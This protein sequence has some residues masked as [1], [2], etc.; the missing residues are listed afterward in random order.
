MNIHFEVL[1]VNEDLIARMIRWYND[2]EIA[3]F[4]HCNFQAQEPP[5]FTRTEALAACAYHPDKFNYLIFDGFTAIGEISITRN[6]FMLHHNVPGSA[7]VSICIGEKEY[8]GKG[9]AQLAMTFL[10]EECRNI[11]FQRIE[12]GVFE[13]NVRA[14]RRYLSLGYREIARYPEFTFSNGS[15]VADIRMEKY[16]LPTIAGAQGVKEDRDVETS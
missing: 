8:W 7:W 3:P 14:Y 6:F 2:A 11:G 4:I 13:N 10:E 1:S 16:L 12:L 5:L 9:I 15:W